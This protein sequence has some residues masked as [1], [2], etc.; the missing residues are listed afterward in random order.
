MIRPDGLAISRGFFQSLPIE[1][2]VHQTQRPVQNYLEFAGKTTEHDT[3]GVEGLQK[4][5][6]LSFFVFLGFLGSFQ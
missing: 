6:L 2:Q 5:D 4:C 3:S 1:S